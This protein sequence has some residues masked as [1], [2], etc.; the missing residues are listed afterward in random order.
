MNEEQLIT[1]YCE[2]FEAAGSSHVFLFDIQRISFCIYLRT[3]SNTLT[4]TGIY[5]YIYIWWWAPLLCPRRSLCHITLVPHSRL[6]LVHSV[7]KLNPG[8]H[9]SPEVVISLPES[10]IRGFVLSP[11][12]L[13]PQQTAQS[14]SIRS[15]LFSPD[16]FS[17]RSNG[18]SRINT[19]GLL[20]LVGSWRWPHYPGGSVC[21]FLR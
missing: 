19:Q 13:K 14:L 15:Q 17:S 12:P 7:G 3:D 2:L 18:Q 20:S 6:R 16:L 11:F 9:N 5:I 8:S 1:D 10:L 21:L 4:D